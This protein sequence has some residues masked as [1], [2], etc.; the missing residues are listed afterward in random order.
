VISSR[1]DG[2]EDNSN[3][4]TVYIEAKRITRAKVILN[5][6]RRSSIVAGSG[7]TINIKMATTA[8]AVTIS[9]FFEIPGMRLRF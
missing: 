5:E 4:L 7:I 3:G 6:I 1:I 2:N 8:T 9:L